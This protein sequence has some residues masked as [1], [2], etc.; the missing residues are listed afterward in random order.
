MRRSCINRGFVCA[1]DIIN[2]RKEDQKHASSKNL[3]KSTIVIAVLVSVKQILMQCFCPKS[4]LRHQ[5]RFIFIDKFRFYVLKI[6]NGFE[7][8]EKLC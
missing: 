2:Y 6:S 8:S 5:I 3:W 7:V 1:R 4:E